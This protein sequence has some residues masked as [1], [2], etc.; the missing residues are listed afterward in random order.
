MLGLG[1]DVGEREALVAREA[2]AEPLQAR[3][4]VGSGVSGR[5]DRDEVAGIGSV[6]DHA[7]SYVGAWT[8]VHGPLEVLGQR[9]KERRSIGG[10]R[11]VPARPS[12]TDRRI[13]EVRIE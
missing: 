11:V 3:P 7:L 10:P 9:A 2:G 12:R 1:Q 5:A 13:I 6:V 8:K 4:G